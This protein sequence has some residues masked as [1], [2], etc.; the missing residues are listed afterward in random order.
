[1]PLLPHELEKPI[2]NTDVLNQEIYYLLHTV[3]RSNYIVKERNRLEKDPSATVH[4][5]VKVVHTAHTQIQEFI[6]AETG[7][8]TEEIFELSELAM[9]INLLH[10]KSVVGLRARLNKLISPDYSLYY[11]ARYEIQTAGILRKKG[12]DVRFIPESKTKSP[13]ILVSSD[14]GGCEIECKHKEVSVD[15]MDYVKSIYNNTQSARKQFSKKYPGIVCIEIN[16]MRYDEFQQ[17]NLR[18]SEEIGRALR[19][20]K[21]I[22]AIMLTSKILF[23]DST[24]YVYRH[25][26]VGYDN[27]YARY[28]FPDWLRMNWINEIG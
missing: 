15:Q 22:S 28:P 16:K 27:P 23:Q 12:L 1:M 21:S 5:F 13:D 20:S 8:M 17:E 4:P 9:L 18:L 25:R 7:G 11:P 14:F 2:S 24:D 10:S 3:L 26:V 19:N 6:K